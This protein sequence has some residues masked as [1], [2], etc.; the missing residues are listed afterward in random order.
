M[1]EVSSL[2]PGGASAILRSLRDHRAAPTQWY[3]AVETGMDYLIFI[4]GLL[5]LTAGLGCLFH[6]PKDRHPSRWPALAIALTA[7][8]LRLWHELLSFAIDIH[9]RHELIGPFFGAL[10]TGAFVT[11][12]LSPVAAGSSTRFAGRW[13]AI[14]GSFG[15]S[16]I[17]AAA[18]PASPGMSIPLGL[19][20]FIAGWRLPALASP[21]NP[22]CPLLKRPIT[23]IILPAA[24][25]PALTPEIAALAHDVHGLKLSAARLYPLLA[26][27]LASIAALTCCAIVWNLVCRRGEGIISAQ[28]RRRRRSGTAFILLAALLTIGNGFWLAH[29]LGT[30]AKK[31]QQSTLLSA[32]H[33]GSQ[34]LDANLINQI[35]GEPGEIT[36]P[37]FQTLRKSLIEIRE[38]LPTSRFC[39]ILGMRGDELVFLVDAEDPGSIETFSPPGDPVED[40][41]EQWQAELAG[42]STFSGPDRD[43]WGVWFS[44]CI[45]I[46][47]ARQEVTALLGVDYPA[48][49]WLKPFAARRLASMGVTLSVFLLLIGLFAFHLNSI[50]TARRVESLSERLSDAMSAAEFDTWECHPSPFRLD[51]GNRIT[52]TLGWEK[53]P[54]F[55]T[56]LKRIH[57]LD[58]RLLFDLAL[59]QEPAETEI[60]VKDRKGQWI[61]FMLRGRNIPPHPGD[62]ASARLVGTVLNIDERQRARIEGDRQRRFAQQV[63]ESV[64]NGLA[65]IDHEGRITYANPAFQRLA[66]ASSGDLTG[67]SI[68]HL[69][70]TPGPPP[71]GHPDGFEATLL[72]LDGVNIPVR[73]YR[74]PLSDTSRNGETIIALIDLTAAKEA[75]LNLLRSRAEANRLAL[76]AKRTDNAVVITDALGRIEWV[77]EGFTKISGY[78]RDEVVGRTPG[79][80]LQRGDEN[81]AARL[82]MRERIR[83]GAGFET[84]IVNHSKDGRSYLVHIE[85]QPLLDKHGK[86]T[87]FMALER[88]I[89]QTRRATNLLEA[90]SGISSRL[91]STRIDDS[92]WSHILTSLGTAA[93]ADRCYYFEVHPHPETGRPA[94]SQTAEWNSGSAT[95]QIHNPELQNVP[96]DESGFA[97]WHTA[98]L[99]GKEICGPVTSF[100][101]SEQPLLFAQDIRSLVVVPVFTGENLVGFLGFDACTEDRI[102]EKWEISILRSAAANIGLRQV[103]QH[104]SDE[105]VLARD[106]AHNAAIAAERANQAKGTFLATMSHEIRTP[107]NAVIGMASLLETTQLDPQQRDFAETILN[108]GS[109]LLDLINDILDYSRIETSKIE[110]D[111]TPFTLAD[112]CREAFEVIRPGTLGKRIELSARINP[113]LPPR[114]A[115]DRAR[116]RQILV[117]LLANAAKFTSAGFISLEV[118]GSLLPSGKWQLTFDVADSGIG[119][120]RE[121]ISRLFSPFVQEDS[122]TTRRFGGSG[123]GLAICKRLAELMDGSISVTSTQGVGSTFHLSILAESATAES[124]AEPPPRLPDGRTPAILIVDDIPANLRIITETLSTW[125]LP[126]RTAPD[127]ATALNLWEKEG[128]FDLV[129]TDHHMPDTDGIALARRLRELPSGAGARICLLSSQTHIPAEVRRD[130]DDVASKPIWPSTLRLMMGRTLSPATQTPPAAAPS[131]HTTFPGLSVLVAEDNENNQKVIRLQLRQLGVEADIVGNGRDAIRAAMARAYD[132]ILLDVQMPVMDGLESCRAIRAASLPK[133]PYIVAITANVFQEDRDSAIA[134]GMDSYMT[135]PI[136]IS[137]IRDALSAAASH[138][139]DRPPLSPAPSPQ[140]I[141]AESLLNEQVLSHLAFL[142]PAEFLEILD[143]TAREIEPGIRRIRD[144]ISHAD[145]SHLASTA[146]KLRGMLLQVGFQ[147]LP[148]LLHDLE[149]HPHSIPPEM[150]TTTAAEIDELWQQSQHAITSWNQTREMP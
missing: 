109:F 137:S 92:L 40:F 72:C 141:P 127:A 5:L 102:W 27:G 12:I 83:A 143:D 68:D 82:L 36:A 18:D 10:A 26:F 116:L 16:F 130:F 79:S 144:A 46:L 28:L 7:T 53:N 43:E 99:A 125:G 55:R 19:A 45:P 149:R 51:L 129:I 24:I 20:A 140:D 136:T 85:C 139:P 86:L 4:I 69:V 101:A 63:M 22:N 91:L 113:A 87:G 135:K 97:R 108:S 50:E 75:E 49:G 64:P 77:N 131:T 80:I 118:D 103:A 73:A 15:L 138:P 61:W 148:E 14:V 145:S 23:C 33:L 126:S 62:P 142:E 58:R 65:V 93:G 90:V 94:M 146:H 8:A 78:T 74:A 39:Y 17:S 3:P 38:A 21:L 121:A 52:R 81:T 6:F 11:F 106:L 37:P 98:L 147:R 120:S 9:G 133:R 70:L 56:V 134:A 48:E 2:S 29:W 67:R 122:S 114:F 124:A 88:D 66:R 100:P 59:Q 31:E 110:L 1:G 71:I 123:L 112:V 105:L 57:P 35:K 41:P 111:S 34:I 115:G 42:E 32:L 107:L 60:R 13:A 117:N 54:S 119:I 47:D 76:V 132:V 150:A 104:E 96:F 44:A 89:T 95:P 84:E 25:I 128:P 30:Q